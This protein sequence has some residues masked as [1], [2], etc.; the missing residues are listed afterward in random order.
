MQTP[1]LP[2][3]ALTAV[4]LTHPEGGL[5]L[6]AQTIK[7]RAAPTTRQARARKPGGRWRRPPTG[8]LP[9]WPRRPTQTAP[10]AAAKGAGGAEGREATEKTV[11]AHPG[12]A[13]AENPLG[14]ARPGG[15]G[16]RQASAE[17]GFTSSGSRREGPSGERLGAGG[18]DSN[19]GAGVRR[20]LPP[21]RVQG[22][23]KTLP[24]QQALWGNQ[25][26]GRHARSP[27]EG[28]PCGD[29]WVPPRASLGTAI[30]RPDGGGRAGRGAV[31][32]PESAPLR[33]KPLASNEA[34]VQRF[35][36]SV[37]AE[38]PAGLSR[39]GPGLRARRAPPGRHRPRQP[40]SEGGREKQNPNTELVRAPPSK[41]NT[42]SVV[43]LRRTGNG[44]NFKTGFTYAP[45]LPHSA[46][47]K[48][49]NKALV[50]REK[51]EGGREGAEG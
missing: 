25:A 3:D 43:T 17:P 31:S 38:P 45:L 6:P 18:E 16:P 33:Y 22:G 26:Q 41:K 9:G 39:Q 47:P 2:G 15:R 50:S 30:L 12:K 13:A 10:R 14:G 49:Q 40:D 24:G 32:G 23:Q 8:C 37:K 28:I 11:T 36:P 35:R 1:S 44:G 19:G 48:R 46:S 20:R 27:G 21:A 51:R 5:S 29:G 34:K 4:S 42:T 7:Q